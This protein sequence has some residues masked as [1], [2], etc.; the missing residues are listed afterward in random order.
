MK[1][2]DSFDTL[3][4]GGGIVGMSVGYGLARQGERVRVLDGSD[5]ALRASR[6]TLA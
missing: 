1:T 5:D 4:L 3:V 6:G 2:E